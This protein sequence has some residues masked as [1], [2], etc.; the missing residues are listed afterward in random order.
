VVATLTDLEQIQQGPHDR[1]LLRGRALHAGE[2]LLLMV[3]DAWVSARVEWAPASGWYA[4]YHA[5]CD[6][7][8]RGHRELTV[9]LVPGTVARPREP[10]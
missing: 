1:L 9:R 3:H 7:P 5:P 8:G 4:L 2:P 6:E 10:A